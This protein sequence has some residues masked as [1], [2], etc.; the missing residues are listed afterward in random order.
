M[1]M[2]PMSAV[3][4]LSNGWYIAATEPVVSTRGVHLIRLDGIEDGNRRAISQVFFPIEVTQSDVDAARVQIDTARNRVIS[5]ESFSMVASEMSGDPASAAT[6]AFWV[7]SCSRISPNSSSP[8]WSTPPRSYPQSQ[9]Y[10]VSSRW[11][12]TS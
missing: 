11:A 5:G 6:G 7:P 3:L 9:T 1:S 12:W 2:L 4:I 8:C 10:G